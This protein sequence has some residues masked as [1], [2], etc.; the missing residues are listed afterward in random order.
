MESRPCS[1]RRGSSW[2]TDCKFHALPNVGLQWS[3]VLCAVAY[4]LL[5]TLSGEQTASAF[6]RPIKFIIASLYAAVILIV[7]IV[8]YHRADTPFEHA[9]RPYELDD[10]GARWPTL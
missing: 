3:L 4:V 8:Q 7:A 9:S 6:K 10:Q 1:T 5:A 2:S